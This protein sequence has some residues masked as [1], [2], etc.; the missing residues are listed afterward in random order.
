MHLIEEHRCAS[1]TFT[2]NHSTSKIALSCAALSANHPQPDAFVSSSLVLASRL[3]EV[4]TLLQAPVV[5]LSKICSEGM[6]FGPDPGEP[7]RNA[8]NKFCGLGVIVSS[9]VG[10]EHELSMKR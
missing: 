3:E 1:C 7:V 4:H 5:N 10:I 6:R 8:A 9:P 2:A